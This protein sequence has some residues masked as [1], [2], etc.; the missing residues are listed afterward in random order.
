MNTIKMTAREF[1]AQYGASPK[2][3]VP[4]TVV[5]LR[6][7]AEYEQESIGGCIAL[8]VQ[9]FNPESFSKSLGDAN[10]NTGP[11][12]L[13]C[14][15]GKR[16]DIAASKLQNEDH[17][18]V[19]IEG[20]LNALKAAGINTISGSRKTI[21]LERQV[22][23]AA[24]SLTIMGVILGATIHP[25]FYGVSAFVGSGLV[26]AGVTDTCGMAMILARMPWNNASKPAN[27][28]SSCAK[29]A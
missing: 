13:L 16:A 19:I 25:A 24:G 4:L 27:Q 26:F 5:D 29:P 8:P 3:K 10:H 15:S 1:L 6:T 14:Q 12:Y 28:P 7:A 9:E 18:L 11:V 23:I 21:S 2:N 17:E 20:G 22:R